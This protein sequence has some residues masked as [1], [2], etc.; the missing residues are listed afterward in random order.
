MKRFIH[1]GLSLF[2]FFIS[3]LM[4]ACGGGS[5]SSSD[6]DLSS[7]NSLSD[8]PDNSTMVATS[9]GSSSVSAD[10]ATAVSGTP[11]LFTALT[12]EP[13]FFEDGFLASVAAQS[14]SVSEADQNE[15]WVG[16]GKCQ[17]IQGAGQTFALISNM[18]MTLCMM[19]GAPSTGIFTLS[20]GTLDDPLTIF[21]Q[22]AD[23][24][25]IKVAGVTE[26]GQGGSQDIYFK[27]YGTNSVANQYKFDVWFCSQGETNPRGLESVTVDKTTGAI[28]QTSEHNEDQFNATISF[29]GKIANSGGTFV[30][31]PTADKTLTLL[32]S[33]SWDGNTN[34]FN[35]QMTVSDG[36][37]SLKAKDSH[38][39]QSQTNTNKVY[40]ISTYTGTEL[41]NV[42]FLTAAF[43]TSGGGGTET[44]SAEGGMEWNDTD[45]NG[46]M[47]ASNVIMDI[48]NTV[49]ALDFSTDSF[50][51]TSPEA[52]AVDLTDVSCSVTADIEVTMTQTQEAMLAMQALQQSCNDFD[53]PN[54]DLCWG[55]S[56]INAA[57][58]A[59]FASQGGPP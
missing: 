25:H 51:S 58:Q 47:Y 38:V 4:V 40:I 35:V 44:W 56:E 2:L 19:Q 5:S 6:S 48:V 31:D 17:T 36:T 10:I 41:S 37:L 34:L 11:A 45:T 53:D 18:G 20:S 30:Y 12:P 7:L 29:S 28:T 59:I 1:S 15:F 39:Q 57:K 54:F 16:E 9:S 50:L 42:R 21:D 23:D 24:R 13:H 32:N 27:V 8:L 22:Q 55:D 3:T 49:S 14:G 46:P 26:G 33:G 43:K 52:P